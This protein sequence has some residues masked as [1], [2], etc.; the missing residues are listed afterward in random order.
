[1]RCPMLWH[2]KGATVGTAFSCSGLL[3][4]YG[5]KC[6]HTSLSTSCV[7]TLGAFSGHNGGLPGP[8]A[9]APSTSYLKV[10]HAQ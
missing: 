9:S 1:M 2:I 5:H 10:Q 7:L 4:C 8:E 6:A 3:W